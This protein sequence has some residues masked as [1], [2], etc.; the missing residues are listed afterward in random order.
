VIGR[1][2]YEY[3]GACGGSG[4][5]RFAD[6]TALPNDW[7]SSTLPSNLLL[8]A[9]RCPFSSTLTQRQLRR[10]GANA[11]FQ[12]HD[13]YELDVNNWPAENPKNNVTLYFEAQTGLLIGLNSRTNMSPG[14]SVSWGN[15]SVVPR[16]LGPKAWPS[17]R[18]GRTVRMRHLLRRLSQPV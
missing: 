7:P 8:R 6:V 16:P 4:P 3:P 10:Y 11:V 15:S 14:G 2:F 5:D 9:K 1:Q 17:I 13:V 18:T 12:G